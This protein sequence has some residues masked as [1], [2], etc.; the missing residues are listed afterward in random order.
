VEG[1]PNDGQRQ[2]MDGGGCPG[3]VGDEKP[4]INRDISVGIASDKNGNARND[5]LVGEGID[6]PLIS[7]CKDATSWGS[8][9][10]EASVEWGN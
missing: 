5:L 3:R 7:A 6:A 4:M 1:V 10:I 2:E 9:S 8:G